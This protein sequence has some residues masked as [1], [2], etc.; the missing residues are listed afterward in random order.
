[1]SRRGLAVR[2]ASMALA[3]PWVV[4]GC[5]SATDEAASD[6][7]HPAVG[8]RIDRWD[9]VSLPIRPSASEALV[10]GS[11]TISEAPPLPTILHFW[12]TWCGPCRAEYPE[13]AAMV[14]RLQSQPFMW[15]SVSSPAGGETTFEELTADTVA[16]FD[17]H[18]IDHSAFC[19]P[20]G[21]TIQSCLRALDQPNLYFPTTFMLDG[22]GTIA[23]VWE[24]YD[25]AGV[26]QM[27]TL[28]K[29]LI[30]DAVRA[31]A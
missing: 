18:G 4:S 27:E 23:G 25:P 17:R 24:G 8:K 5:G 3:S 2:L 12:G 20:R 7:S 10:A 9:L 13:L 31:V 21:Q 1:M 30:D 15:L 14:Q 26:G 19:D 28:L 11:V 6:S 22:S 16:F 29:R